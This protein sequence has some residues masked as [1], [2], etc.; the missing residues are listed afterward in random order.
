MSLDDLTNQTSSDQPSSGTSP[1]RKRSLTWL[2]PAGLLLGFVLIL[3]LL[4]GERL[5]PA[6]EVNT[7]PV[8]TA[9]A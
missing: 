2:L 3:T 8:I 1:K 6:A 5:I 4:F 9:R 7:A